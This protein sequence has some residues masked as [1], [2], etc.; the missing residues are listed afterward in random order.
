MRGVFAHQEG[1]YAAAHKSRDAPV[2]RRQRSFLYLTVS[3]RNLIDVNGQERPVV[4]VRPH[5]VRRP[6]APSL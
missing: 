5:A 6:P 2:P 4:E 3:L 1:R